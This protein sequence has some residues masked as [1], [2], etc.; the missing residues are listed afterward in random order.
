M[1]S[2]ENFESKFKQI[3]NSAKWRELQQTFNEA[4]HIFL[5]GH[6]GNLGVADH[7]AIDMSRLTDK[8]VIAPGSGTLVTSI[9]SDESFETWLAKWLELRSRG[10]D[11][12]K[13]LAI[14]I[15]CSTTGASSNSLVNALNWSVDNNINS[16]L[17]SAQPKEGLDERIIPISFDVI[18]YHTSELL[19][20]ALVY[21]LIHG[22]GFKCPSIAGK[23]NQRRFDELGIES[24]VN[25]EISNLNVPPGFENEQKNIAVDFDGVIHNMDKGWYDGTCYGEPLRGSLDALKELSEKW[26]V[27][28]FTAKARPDRPLVNGKTGIE[29]V[30]DWL[31][32][33]DVRKYIDYVT[34]EKPRAEYYIDDRG[35]TFRD[36]WNAILQEVMSENK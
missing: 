3:G 15:S 14:G 30:E 23:A 18:N 16:C 27:I 4:E 33:Y 35:I 22:A 10:L 1:V 28:I 2:I 17:W 31:E 21:E 26:N 12:S 32:K 6:G 20:L 19:S 29:L 24:E 9:I 7:G 8:N 13:C 11:K 34:W 25:T 36:N 5:F